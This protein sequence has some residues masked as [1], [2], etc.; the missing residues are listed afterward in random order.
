MKTLALKV[1]IGLAAA[2]FMIVSVLFGASYWLASDK[3]A[4]SETEF[5]ENTVANLQVTMAQPIFTYDYEQIRAVLSVMLK[6]AQIYHI[7]VSDHRGKVLAESQQAQTVADEYLV[8]RE[9]QFAE[10]G[11][12]TGQLAIQFSMLPI[13]AQLSDLLLGYFLQALLILG[14]SLFVIFII[15]KRLVIN[16]LGNVV[17]AMEE[18]AS[19]DGDLCHRLPVE[20]QDEIGQLAKAFNGFVEQIHGTISRVHETSGQLLGDAKALGSLSQTN[21]DR[22]QTQLKETEAAVTAVTQLSA[23]ANEVAINAKRTADAASQADKAVDD[24]QRQ[25]DSGLDITRKLASELARSA[26]SISQLQQETQKIDE[27]VV[28][29]NSIAEQTNLLALNAAIEAGEQGRGFAVVADEVRTLAS[30]TQQ[31]TGEIQK[32]IQ[33]VQSRVAETVTVMQAS[34]ALSTQGVNRSEEIKLVLTKVTDLVS[35]ISNMNIEVSHAAQEQT[36]VTEAISRTLNDLA[37][38]SGSASLDS[39]HLAHSS[40]RLFHQGERLWTLVTSFRL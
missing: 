10:Q 3:L 16:P 30:R 17:R 23:S 9:I 38:V 20:S 24:S 15:L 39:E 36:C 35:N 31:A 7:V 11:N 29:I 22:V 8:K 27:V 18:I 19:G 1:Q 28:V 32:M 2:I 34:Q 13:R 5:E 25:F 37:N 4:A 6:S 33:Q 14:G 21:N 12:P 40:E 26:L